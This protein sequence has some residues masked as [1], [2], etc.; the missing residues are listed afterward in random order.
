[1]SSIA[2]SRSFIFEEKKNDRDDL[3]IRNT[4]EMVC[5]VG[6]PRVYCACLRQV[7]M[8]IDT[9]MCSASIWLKINKEIINSDLLK[10]TRE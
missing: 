7:E 1:M 8:Q 6:L 3:R 5:I 10:K 4:W 2:L 9:P